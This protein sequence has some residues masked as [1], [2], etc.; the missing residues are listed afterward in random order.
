LTR[1]LFFFHAKFDEKGLSPEIPSEVP[2]D[3]TK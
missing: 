1:D 3:K 2:G